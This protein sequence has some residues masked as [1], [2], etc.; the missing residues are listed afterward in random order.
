VNEKTG[1]EYQFAYTNVLTAYGKKNDDETQVYAASGSLDIMLG[2]KIVGWKHPEH[3]GTIYVRMVHRHNYLDPDKATPMYFGFENGASHLVGT[4]FRDYTFRFNELQYTQKLFDSRLGFAIGKIDPTNYFTAHALIA[5]TNQFLGY[6]IASHPVINWPDPGWGFVLAGAPH[7]NIYVGFGLHDARGDVYRDGQP[8][9]G[10]RDF[11][12]GRFFYVAEVG[13]VASFEERYFKRIS[14]NYSHT[15]QYV[16][17]V[18]D[19][20]SN[21]NNSYAFNAMWMFKEKF[22]PMVKFGI[23]NGEGFNVLSRANVAVANGMRFKSHDILGLG[24]AWDRPVGEDPRDQ[25]IIE[26]YYRLNLMDNFE[27]SPDLQLVIH[28]AFAPNTDIGA[29]ISIRTRITL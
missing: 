11:F 19:A 14:F 8:L 28:P 23:S 24:F 21:V 16:D 29:Y 6:A 13:Y 20:V 3:N 9:Y 17:A 7:P 18:A 1:L 10:G 5:P 25:Y 26:V 15:A 4:T 2:A 27:I 12:D 22:L